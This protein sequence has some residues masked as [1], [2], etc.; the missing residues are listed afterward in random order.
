MPLGS[1]SSTRTSSSSPSV[2][3][4]LDALDALAATELGDVHQ[5]VT[6]GKDVDERTELGDVD[7]PAL[8]GLADL[9][10]SAG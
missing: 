6:A 2:D 8:V 1:T 4:V 7:D 9:G 5:A 3:D 10:A